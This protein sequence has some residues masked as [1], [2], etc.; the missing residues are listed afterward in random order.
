MPLLLERHG[1]T[2]VFLAVGDTAAV[3]ADVFRVLGQLLDFVEFLIACQD[4]EMARM[5]TVA[6]VLTHGFSSS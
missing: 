1:I 5:V 3:E 4:A 6:H 2:Q